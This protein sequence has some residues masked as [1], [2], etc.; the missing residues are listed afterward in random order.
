MVSKVVDIFVK[1]RTNAKELAGT[2]AMPQKQFGKLINQN[3][4]VDKGMTKNVSTMGRMGL[5]LRH[6]T[7]GARGFRMEMLG[8]MFFGMMMQKTF[9]G[10]LQPALQM[11]G[12]MELLSTI[13]GLMFLPVGLKLI[14]W[15]MKLWDWWEN[16]S[17]ATKGFWRSIVVAGVAIGGILMLF[18]QFALGIGS[19][20]QVVGLVVGPIIAFIGWIISIGTTILAIFGPILGIIAIFTLFSSAVAASSDVTKE[21]ETEQKSIWQ[22]IKDFISGAFKS[23]IGW[24]DDLWERFLDWGPINN[25]LTEMGMTEEAINKLKDPIDTV[26]EKLDGWWDKFLINSPKMTAWFA[27]FGVTFDELSNPIENFGIIFGKVFDGMIAKVKELVEEF[28]VSILGEDWK[29]DIENLVK[30]FESVAT[31]LTDIATAAGK[32]VNSEFFKIVE[33]IL[34]LMSGGIETATKVK[35]VIQTKDVKDY[36]DIPEEPPP[37][38]FSSFKDGIII[39]INIGTMNA[40]PQ[41]V[42]DVMTTELDRLM[43]TRT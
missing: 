29:T 7:V 3:D 34:S 9:M 42:S 1:F 33:Y 28:M 11:S 20:I 41:E 5:G 25:F 36:F 19:L 23:I 26:R 4:K 2:I 8:V 13:I 18:G 12:A 40:T 17:E 22:R 32:I 21:F 31:S 24:V 16:A 27:K 35:D 43:R 6:L 15:I 10:M 37:Q 38:G 14:D 30:Q 39:N